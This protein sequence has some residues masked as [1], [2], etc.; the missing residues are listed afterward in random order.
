MKNQRVEAQLKALPAKPGVYLFRGED[1][2]V[3]YIGKAKSLRPRVR[4][5]FQATP[6]TRAQIAQLPG[7]VADIEVIVTSTEAEALHVEQNLV[8]RHRP[9]FNIRLRDDKS[10]PY[11]AVTVE[12]EYPRVMFTRERHRRGVVYFGPYANAK[13]VRET[14][15]VLNRVFQ[16]RPCEG[17]K[18]GRHSGIPCLDYHIE[19]CKAP[20][21]GYVSKEEYREIIDHVVEFLSGETGPILRKL[22]RQMQE[23]AAEERFEDAARYRNRLYAIR[24]LAERQAA[25]RR[26]VGTV[27]VIGI[28]IEG[29]RAAVQIFPLRDGKLVDRYGFHLENVAGRD[30]AAALEAFVLEYYGSAPSVPPQLVVPPDAGDTVALEQFLSERRGS[31]VEVRAPERGEKK[32]LQE[33]AAQ[34][35]RVALESDA[36]Q[37]EQRRVRRVEALEE[38][39]ETLNLESLPIRIECYDI[40]NIQAESPVGSMVVFQ[41]AVAKKAHYRK[42]GVRK[43][44]AGPDDFAAIEEVVSR[45]FARLGDAASDDYDES[46]AAVPNLVVIDGGKGQLSAALAAMQAY[47]LPR[48]AVVSLAKRAEEVFVPGRSEP[49][50]LPRESAGLQLLQRIRDEAH[51]FA[52]GFHRQ[53]RETRARG[54]IFDDLQGVGP[55]RRRALLRHFGSAER[56]LEASQEELEGVPGVPAKTARAIYAQLHKAG[57][58]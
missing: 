27:D 45:R 21:V 57:R 31:R 6:D 8:K 30:T 14:L 12:D 53:R 5:Y 28:A 40:S 44:E 38:L 49:I 26:S 2:R 24:H 9:P 20:C 43:L 37:A 23:A 58:G 4:S 47:D 10:F 52:L 48:V 7:R 29:D 33:L 18:P 22:E 11:I 46:F 50:M 35:A 32:R 19:R 15:D 34:N 54:S 1:G 17:P 16:Y 56:L 51:R 41:D 55:A 3:L 42:F 25:D 36:I 39:R 13:K